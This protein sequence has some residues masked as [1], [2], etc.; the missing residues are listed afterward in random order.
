MSAKDLVSELKVAVSDTQ[1]KK[2]MSGGAIQLAPHQVNVGPSSIKMDAKKVKKI[3]RAAQK[4]KGIRMAMSP[5]ELQM[6]GDGLWDLLKSGAKWLRDNNLIRPLLKAGVKTVLPIAAGVFGGPAGAAAAT[7]VT[8]KYGDEAVD[9]VGDLVGFGLK[10]GAVKRQKKGKARKT[11]VPKVPNVSLPPVRPQLDNSQLL[12]PPTSAAYNPP[13]QMPDQSVARFF[14]RG[15][16]RDG[17]VQTG[18]GLRGGSFKL[19]GY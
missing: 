16:S 3:M 15:M 19:A 1:A 8:Q 9:K 11:A 10:G 4:G 17:V 6:N 12:I 13:P 18:A 2:L 14:P 5:Q 7:S